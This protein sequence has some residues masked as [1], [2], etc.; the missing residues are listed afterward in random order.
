VSYEIVF[1]PR[2]AGG[3]LADA[4]AAVDRAD[5][6]SDEERLRWF[7]RLVPAAQSVLGDV[8]AD[9]GGRIVRHSPTGL[10]LDVRPGGIVIEV[11][12]EGEADP[13]TLMTLAHTMAGDVER[14]TGLVGWDPQLGEPVSTRIASFPHAP[15]PSTAAGDDEDDRGGGAGLVPAAGPAAGPA[16][17]RPHRAWWRFWA[18]R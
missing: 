8:E 14:V 6:V 16:Q 1:V 4:V 17:P 18:R 12:D 10:R 3:S 13:L 5:D 15:P 2:S 9:E 11:P 7:E